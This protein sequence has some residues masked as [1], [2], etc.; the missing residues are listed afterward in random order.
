MARSLG[1]QAH[2]PAIKTRTS[3][4]KRAGVISRGL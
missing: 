1:H 3:A 4:T 2:E